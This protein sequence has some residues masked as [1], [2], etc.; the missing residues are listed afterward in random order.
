M[1]ILTVIYLGI[2][3]IRD[4]YF[5]SDTNKNAEAN[6]AF[7]NIVDIFENKRIELVQHPDWLGHEGTI[8]KCV[9]YLNRAIKLK[10]RIHIDSEIQN[11]LFHQFDLLVN[12]TGIP[13]GTN[14]IKPSDYQN[15]LNM[16]DRFVKLD[17]TDDSKEKLGR[18]KEY[19]M[20]FVSK[21][22]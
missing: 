9:T 22:K 18:I 20:K 10:E 6:E 16:A 3:I 14:I 11:S 7:L 5:K 21:E 1:G 13:W 19:I 8:W 17:L 12:N 15:I 2:E 4:K